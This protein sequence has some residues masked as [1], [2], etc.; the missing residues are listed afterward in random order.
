MDLFDRVS[1]DIRTAMKAHDRAALDALRNVKKLFLEARTAPGSD[2]TLT[3]EQALTLIRKLVKQGKESAALYAAQGRAD[4]AEAEEAQV[5][6]IEAYLPQALSEEELERQIGAL[7]AELGA[8]SPR[9]MGR[10]MGQAT[11]RLAGVAEGAAIA[12]MVKKLLAQS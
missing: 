2:G 10:V 7:I 4:L 3:D 8:T 12:A 9:D 1:E 5:R 6:V 11:R